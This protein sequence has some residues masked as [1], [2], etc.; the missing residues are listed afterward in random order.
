M[1]NPK[2]EL[3]ARSV[4]SSIFITG[5]SVPRRAW[6]RQT[7]NF[8]IAVILIAISTPS[9]YGQT[10]SISPQGSYLFV[11]ASAPNTPPTSIPD[12][13]V[14]PLIITLSAIGAKPGDKITLT[15]GGTISNCFPGQ[16]GCIY[17][18]AP[19]CAL[20]STS[21]VVNPPSSGINRVSG[22]LM[23]NFSEVNLCGPTGPT[24]FG[25]F[26]TDIPQDFYLLGGSTA[27]ATIP[28]NA[29]YLIV[30]FPDTVYLDNA[31]NPT[32]SVV[33]KM[34]QC[35]VGELSVIT[36][37]NALL[38]ENNSYASNQP[39]LWSLSYPAVDLELH[40]NA[41]QFQRAINSP[42]RNS[43]HRPLAYQA[44][45]RNIRDVDYELQRKGEAVAILT[46]ATRGGL[47]AVDPPKTPA[48]AD[49]IAKVNEEI[50]RHG[51]AKSKFPTGSIWPLAVNMPTASKHTPYPSDALDLAVS[52]R[53]AADKKLADFNLT[54]IFS[55]TA[56][57][58]ELVDSRIQL[59]SAGNEDL[60]VIIASPLAIMV[61]DP[62]GKRIGF[63]P[64][65]SSVINEI[66][67]DALYLGRAPESQNIS[68]ART[69]PGVYKVTAFAVGVGP[70]HL[71]MTRVGEH[72]DELAR[73]DTA[74]SVIPGQS[75][76][77][78]LSAPKYVPL[79]VKPDDK[80]NVVNFTSQG[81]VPFAVLSAPDFNAPS[82]IDQSSVTIGKVGTEKSVTRCTAQDVNLDGAPDLLCHFKMRATGLTNADSQIVLKAKTVSG[83]EVTGIDL[84]SAAPP[85]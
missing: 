8:L 48:C 66:G 11:N 82:Q 34:G 29:A 47:K 85:K 3:P 27:T 45:F 6:H 56:Y 23:P 40:I 17:Q 70:Y 12:V 32:V 25:G 22:A 65:T 10:F 44:H 1:L 53:N 21:N 71:S 51:I 75:V 9:I 81:E 14:P 69:I 78:S 57:H 67:S 84:L 15:A 76:E 31:G 58:V 60:E 49:V 26:P 7:C 68:I 33:V 36:D 77:L 38:F 52:N 13:V 30:A 37:P 59:I 42:V 35:P 83:L 46:G 4:L 5:R 61:T 19:L 28:A 20:F 62:S 63:N 64:A 39:P 2:I 18:P 72:G 74:G 55:E 54:R 80:T 41:G 79:D 24:G 50:S 43:G 16:V 73:V